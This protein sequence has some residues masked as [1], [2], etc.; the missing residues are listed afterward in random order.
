MC[1]FLEVVV[2]KVKVKVKV[3]VESFV[4]RIVEDCGVAELDEYE[5]CGI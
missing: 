1:F 3:K 2:I 5:Y 4:R